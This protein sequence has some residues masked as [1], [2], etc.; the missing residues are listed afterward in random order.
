MI[1]TC[2]RCCHTGDDDDFDRSLSDELFC[3]A[4]GEYF[5]YD[6]EEEDEEDA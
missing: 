3:P 2:P 4:C 5:F 1:F 6:P